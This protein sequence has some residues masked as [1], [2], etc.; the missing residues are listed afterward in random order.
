VIGGAALRL[1][2]PEFRVDT[3]SVRDGLVLEGDYV[4][5]SVLVKTFTGDRLASSQNVNLNK[6]I[7]SARRSDLPLLGDVDHYDTTVFNQSQMPRLQRELEWLLPRVELDEQGA[8]SALL[9]L[10]VL[11]GDKPHRYLVFNGD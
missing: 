11:V 2:I 3:L 5:M 10:A 7:R 4:A 1:C 8:I 6:L 9:E